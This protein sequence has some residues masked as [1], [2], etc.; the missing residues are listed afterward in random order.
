MYHFA[1]Q[2]CIISLT[3][4]TA[5]SSNWEERFHLNI[6]WIPS[7]KLRALPYCTTCVY[8]YG[9]AHACVR[10]W[11]YVCT[12]AWTHM[13]IC[14]HTYRYAHTHKH[15]YLDGEFSI[16]FQGI[17]S[18]NPIE[19]QWDL[20]GKLPYEYFICNSLFKFIV[21]WWVASRSSWPK[22]RPEE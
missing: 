12:Q 19:L 22:Q 3:E 7:V 10:V 18:H 4:R 21:A 13:Y 11:V 16:G 6:T 14:A 20:S 2:T 15:P 1:A 17:R 5:E 9:P 8:T